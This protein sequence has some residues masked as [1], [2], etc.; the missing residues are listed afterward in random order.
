VNA[1]RDA[2]AL[3]V[4]LVAVEA[5]RI[6]GHI[7]VSPV[8]IDDR[9]GG[10]FGIGP[11]S[12]DPDIQRSGTGTALVMAALDRLRAMGAEGCVVL[13][14]PGYY[15]RFGFVGDPDLRYGGEVSP[16]FQRLILSGPAASGEVTYHAAFE[17]R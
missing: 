10:W 9:P 5:G 3:T 17:A 16:Y 2:D 6:A 4:S 11:L 14:Q 8:R 12:V 15:G 13:G 7:A 1:L